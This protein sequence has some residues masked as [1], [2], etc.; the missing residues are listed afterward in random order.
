M[1]I[2]YLQITTAIENTK[3]TNYTLELL[4]AIPQPK[5]VT[6]NVATSN[7]VTIP[8][9]TSVPFPIGSQVLIYQIGAGNTSIVG[10]VGV[11]I[12]SVFANKSVLYQYAICKLVKT[13][14]NTWNLQ[15]TQ[16]TE[17]TTTDPTVNDDVTKNY[18]LGSLWFN[19]TTRKCYIL[20]DNS[21]GAA[22][23][24]IITLTD[25]DGNV[26]IPAGIQFGG[27]YAQVNI[28]ANTNNL[29][30]PNLANVVLVRLTST[31]N[32]N[33]TGIQV[34]NNTIAYFFSIFNVNP[35]TP[36]GNITFKNNNTSSLAENRFELGN[37]VVLQSGEG[38]TFIYDPVSQRWRSPGKNI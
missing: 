3:T 37:D 30:I 32:Y 9:N 20:M 31:G 26:V 19:T 7:T 6:M 14:I 25:D 38:L 17:R 16:R 11:T 8:N 24:K 29:V 21:T 5:V 1:A 23:W 18:V 4:D 13:G 36:V 10:D 22:I 34:P 15:S 12:D 33:L 2:E 35:A 27:A 28:T